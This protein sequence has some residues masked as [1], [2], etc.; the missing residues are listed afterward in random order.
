M[1]E[2]G[3][4]EGAQPVHEEVKGKGSI[5]EKHFNDILNRK[6]GELRGIHYTLCRVRE[7]L[8]SCEREKARLWEEIKELQNSLDKGEFSPLGDEN[9]QLHLEDRMQ[10]GL[11]DRSQTAGSVGPANIQRPQ[12]GSLF[13]NLVESAPFTGRSSEPISSPGQIDPAQ[14]TIGYW[15]KSIVNAGGILGGARRLPHLGRVFMI[16]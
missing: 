11:T 1:D 3:V 9:D 2:R 12:I 5:Q 6:V 14:N 13:Q 8:E 15:A 10:L 4:Q 16:P 7:T